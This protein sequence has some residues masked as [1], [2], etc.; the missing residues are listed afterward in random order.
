M[1]GVRAAIRSARFE[2]CTTL[3]VR[4]TVWIAL[5]VPR[6]T[7]PKMATS[8]A[9]TPTMKNQFSPSWQSTLAVRLWGCRRRWWSDLVCVRVCVCACKGGGAR[10]AVAPLGGSRSRALKQPSRALDQPLPACFT[11]QSPCWDRTRRDRLAPPAQ[12]AGGWGGWRARGTPCAAGWRV[13]RLARPW[14]ISL[15]LPTPLHL[16]PCPPWQDETMTSASRSLAN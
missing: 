2:R 12:P 8:R 5:A 6:C 1:L 15:S 13:G 10:E 16:P 14:L 11:S 4:L 9:A 7:V 3:P